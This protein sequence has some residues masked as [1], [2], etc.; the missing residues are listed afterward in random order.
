MTV[1]WQRCVGLGCFRSEF[2]F[3]RWSFNIIQEQM[4]HLSNFYFC[5]VT[6]ARAPHNREQG[7]FSYLHQW[8]ASLQLIIM[9][10]LVVWGGELGLSGSL[11][12]VLSLMAWSQHLALP[13]SSSCHR[14]RLGATKWR[15]PGRFPRCSASLFLQPSAHCDCFPCTGLLIQDF[16]DLYLPLKPQGPQIHHHHPLLDLGMQ[17]GMVSKKWRCYKVPPHSF[18]SRSP[19]CSSFSCSHEG[20]EVG[21]NQVRNALEK[22]LNA[23]RWSYGRPPLWEQ[24]REDRSCSQW[25]SWCP[26]PQA[27][28]LMW[29][30]L[31][32]LCL[33]AAT[34]CLQRR[35]LSAVQE[36]ILPLVCWELWSLGGRYCSWQ[37]HGSLAAH[38]CFFHCILPI[39]TSSSL[40]G[41][42]SNIQDGLNRNV[43]VF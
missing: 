14:W 20:G 22:Y 11:S 12:W 37:I 43:N 36:Q 13:H 38:C 42:H 26:S 16:S 30:L 6:D 41:I 4:S 29:W 10:I 5:R 1:L 7:N 2:S 39:K 17:Q 40:K 27:G 15:L 23:H 25:A 24:L 9:G 32:A 31:A 33:F 21:V 34:S 18:Q 28:T 8:A 35:E 3:Q 19:P